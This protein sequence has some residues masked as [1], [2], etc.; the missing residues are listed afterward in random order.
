MVE[1]HGR[2]TQQPLGTLLAYLHN[3]HHH[4]VQVLQYSF[5]GNSHC[6]DVLRTQIVRSRLISRGHANAVVP[7]SIDFNRQP[8]RRAIE[9]KHIYSGW[10]LAAELKSCGPLSKF[11]P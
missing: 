8:H 9:I 5:R 7:E 2:F 4:R 10:M 1:G 3:P 6:G 11:A